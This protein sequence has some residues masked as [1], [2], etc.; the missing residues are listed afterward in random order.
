MAAIQQPMDYLGVNYYTRSVVSASGEEWNAK[1]R[2]LPVSDMDWEIYPQGLTD[3]LLLLKQDYAALPPVYVTENGGAF[4]DDTVVDGRVQDDDRI[5]YL[6]THI[7][8]V[9]SAMQQGVPMAGY[10]VWSLM[11]NFEWASGYLKRFGIVHV[12]YGTQTRTP[13]A[14]ADWYRAFLRDWRG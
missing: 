14:S 6:R 12:D 13:K 10:M 11:D 8:A 1:G 5:N 9:A 4:K 3:L 7:A 2:G